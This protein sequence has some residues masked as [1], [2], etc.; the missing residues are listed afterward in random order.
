M[1]IKVL[2]IGDIGNTIQTIQKFVKKSQIHL[3]NY[4]QDGSAFYV[5]AEDVELF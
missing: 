2:A 4:P 3:I 5:N 1:V